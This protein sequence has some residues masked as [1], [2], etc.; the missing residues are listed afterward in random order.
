MPLV[1][2]VGEFGQ[3][4][5]DG[6]GLLQAIDPFGR[7]CLLLLRTAEPEFDTVTALKGAE[8]G[9]HRIGTESRRKEREEGRKERIGAKR[10]RREG[11]GEKGK[12]EK[13]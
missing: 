10:E 9:Q 12:G 2:R 11:R 6:E 4:E 8:Q 7:W 1:L 13:V 5:F 3:F